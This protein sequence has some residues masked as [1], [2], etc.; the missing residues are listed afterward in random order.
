VTRNPPAAAT[1]RWIV[2]GTAAV[3]LFHFTDNAINVDTYPKA[4]WQPDWFPALVVIGWFLYTAVGVAGW[5]LYER[6]RL[7]AAHACL[8]IYGY[9]VA[10]SL[11]HFLYGSPDELTTRGLISVL[12]DVAAGLLVIAVA[13]WSIVAQRAEGARASRRSRASASRPPEPAR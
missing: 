11:G 3:S 9:L 8:L 4:G 2:L 10:S 5:R 13:L 6:G 1:V 7:R 12:V